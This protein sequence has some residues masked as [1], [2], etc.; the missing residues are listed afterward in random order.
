MGKNS[1]VCRNSE[2]GL[3]QFYFLYSMKMIL[4]AKSHGALFV[5]AYFWG[6]VAFSQDILWNFDSIAEV[7]PAPWAANGMPGFVDGGKSIECNNGIFSYIQETRH[8]FF[9]LN[10][11]GAKFAAREY[12][13]M[14]MKFYASAPGK[15]I[16]YYIAEGGEMAAMDTPIVTCMGWNEYEVNLSE[17]TFGKHYH[18]KVDEVKKTTSWGG[19]SQTI[20][21][22]R[23]DPWFEAGTS[24][25]F[26]YIKFVAADSECGLNS[27]FTGNLV[28]NSSFEACSNPGVPDHWGTFHWGVW[29]DTACNDF[30]QWRS[31]WTPD[32]QQKFHGK[33]SFSIT[34]VKK[35]RQDDYRLTSCQISI[36]PGTHTFSAYLKGEKEDMRV[37]ME[38]LDGWGGALKKKIVTLSKQWERYSFSEHLQGSMVMLSIS[39]LDLGTVWIDAVQLEYGE[40]A[41]PYHLSSL[42]APINTEQPVRYGVAMKKPVIDG[43]LNQ[44]EWENANVFQL[45]RNSGRGK[46]V[47]PTQVFL[48]ADSD[49]LYIGLE[50]TQPLI[51]SFHGN[52]MPRD[53]QLWRGKDSIQIFLSPHQNAK[54]YFLFI[55]DWMGNRFDSRSCNPD[56]DGFWQVQSTRFN[57]G[58]ASEIAIPWALLKQRSDNS[59]IWR[60]NICRENKAGNENTALFPVHGTFHT[61]RRF[62]RLESVPGV[63]LDEI[64]LDLLQTEIV[65][66]ACGQ[67]DLILRLN[68]RKE[69]KRQLKIITTLISSD[70]QDTIPAQTEIEIPANREI[71]TTVREL[72]LQ[73]NDK[74]LTIQVEIYEGATLCATEI[75][76]IFRQ[77]D[78]RFELHPDLSFYSDESTLDIRARS[79]FQPDSGDLIQL[80]ILD[81]NNQPITEATMAPDAVHSLDLSKLEAGIYQLQASLLNQSGKRLAYTVRD[82]VKMPPAPV[83][84]KLDLGNKCLLSSGK[85]MIP[86]AIIWEK[87]LDTLSIKTLETMK[88]LGFNSISILIRPS[89]N[90]EQIKIFLDNIEK[91]GLKCFF[92]FW[93]RS[94]DERHLKTMRAFITKFQSHPAILA[95]KTLDEPDGWGGEAFAEKA[96]QFNKQLDPYRPSMINF[97]PNQNFHRTLPSD[98]RC[99]DHYPVPDQDMME[100]P[101]MVEAMARS[102]LPTWIILQSTGNAYFYYRE[103]SA[104]EFDFMTISSL[105]NGA[106][107][108]FYFAQ[109]PHS[110]ALRKAMPNLFDFLEKHTLQLLAGPWHEGRVTCTETI[111]AATKE[112]K[113]K[114]YILALN[115]TD[116][117]QQVKFEISGSEPYTRATD[118]LSKN[119][120]DLSN[121][122]FFDTFTAFQYKWYVMEK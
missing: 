3:M 84:T 86:I 76:K 64:M 6:I 33:Q 9:N 7:A 11:Q 47:H 115:I 12:N 108:F 99:L 109:M 17:Q 75:K 79:L 66:T 15:I 97:T 72:H 54:P 24:V 57:G 114:K 98:I 118:L 8:S 19:N 112:Y 65:N 45:H 1:R 23:I 111:I 43:T 37:M 107:G 56:W 25:K 60:I 106:S 122:C 110:K 81:K 85:P 46:V 55:S 77:P 48:Q 71:T 30:D 67:Y 116:S 10:F 50:C 74:Y 70:T 68:N 94:P 117:D 62:G 4:S 120:I 34:L 87:G 95:W 41:T 91:V 82:L 53:S 38:I 102:G 35:G 39:P 61:P 104:K 52:L 29:Q 105:I 69:T 63:Q 26:D 101:F 92:L 31:L 13:I 14:E 121:N 80:K 20:C 58:W 93:I 42:D 89:T 32:R 78:F 22:I 90:L 49:N 21:G 119:S 73:E 96:Y 40:A 28:C 103:P 5:F 2:K 27:E 100:I 44:S 59:T 16:L 88:N 18:S 83:E 113:N 36:S 51:N